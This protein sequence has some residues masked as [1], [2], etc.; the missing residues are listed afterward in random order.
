MKRNLLLQCS[1]SFDESTGRVPQ[2][3]INSCLVQAFCYR[4]LCE[5]KST[6]RPSVSAER[7]E[8]IRQSFVHSP[9]KSVRRASKELNVTN[10][11]VWQVLHLGPVTTVV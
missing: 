9:H 7:V 6:G 1:D 3:T 11:A 5:G 4:W 8:T 10:T 2:S